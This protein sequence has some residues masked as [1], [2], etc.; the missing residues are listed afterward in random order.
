MVL[1]FGY[2]CC[3]HSHPSEYI[4]VSCFA[5]WWA[6]GFWSN[7][8]YWNFSLLD[9]YGSYYLLNHSSLWLPIWP[10]HSEEASII[11]PAVLPYWLLRFHL[12]SLAPSLG[13][14]I[15]GYWECFSNFQNQARC[16]R[17][18][19]S[20]RSQ[21]M[22]PWGPWWAYYRG[23]ECDF[24][25]DQVPWCILSKLRDSYWFLRHQFWS[26]Y[27]DR[28]YQPLFH[29]QPDQWSWFFQ[30]SSCRFVVISVGWHASGRSRHWCCSG[31]W[32]ALPTHKR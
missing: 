18:S 32:C 6:E 14:R 20:C 23:R 25:P 19:A 22:S 8:K 11:W 7:A 17:S 9:L 24:C 12:P 2:S 10:C 15:E 3:D 30:L 27:S 1:E 13:L 5:V 4:L 28:L 16:C 26:V 21:W 29:S 31:W